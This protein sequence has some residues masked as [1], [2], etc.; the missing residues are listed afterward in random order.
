M[1]LF[2]KPKLKLL[3]LNNSP[4]PVIFAHSVENL[5]VVELMKRQ[6][7]RSE[8]P[9]EF[10]ELDFGETKC[11]SLK[12]RQEEFTLFHDNRKTQL[13][14]IPE[15]W[16]DISSQYMKYV[17]YVRYDGTDKGGNASTFM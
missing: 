16:L 5:Y 13:V 11:V 7:Q 4:K 2:P 6:N 14:V 17:R 1:I 9:Y 10:H 12:L 8:H 15:S 3:E